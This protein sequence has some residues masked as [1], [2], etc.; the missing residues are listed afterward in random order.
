MAKI[1]GFIKNNSLI[2]AC[3]FFGKTFYINLIRHLA[4]V[5]DLDLIDLYAAKC[6]LLLKKEKECARSPN[7]LGK[8]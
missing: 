6:H 4:A 7:V 1:R 8:H 3:Y 2:P 5:N